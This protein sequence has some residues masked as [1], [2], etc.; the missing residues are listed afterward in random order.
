MLA[1]AGSGLA[2]TAAA[3]GSDHVGGN[4]AE[5]RRLA[6]RYCRTCHVLTERGQ[7]GWTDAPAFPVIA[8]RGGMS[9]ARIEALLQT[10]PLHML[11]MPR[12][13]TEAADLA[14]FVMSLR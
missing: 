9:A 14:A 3:Q 5:G 2:G 12:S 13:P 8:A 6:E 7:A 4:A 1:L 11:N 10:S